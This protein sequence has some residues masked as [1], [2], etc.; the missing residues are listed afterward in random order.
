MMYYGFWIYHDDGKTV[1]K[2]YHDEQD[3][4]D[5]KGTLSDDELK[6]LYL[7]Y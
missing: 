4:T 3:L 1:L 2:L 6:L 5:K 7:Y